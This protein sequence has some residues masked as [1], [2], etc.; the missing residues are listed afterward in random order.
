MV[1]LVLMGDQRK[2]L[3]HNPLTQGKFVGSILVAGLEALL[4]LFLLPGHV[5]LT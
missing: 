5:F 3:G 4:S 2:L 1:G